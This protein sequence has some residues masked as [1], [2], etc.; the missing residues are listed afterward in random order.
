[1][2][3]SLM[4]TT[5]GM[6]LV[7]A[8]SILGSVLAGRAG[9][10]DYTVRPAPPTLVRDGATTLLVDFSKEKT[11]ADFAAGNPDLSLDPAGFRKNGAYAG[12]LKIHTADNLNP[13]AWTLELVLRLP[14]A[15]AAKD[16]VLGG[17]Q[18][19]KG[20]TYRTRFEIRKGTGPRFVLSS[21]SPDHG[22]LLQ[23]S[24]GGNG[25]TLHRD[26]PAEWVYL[27][28]GLDLENRRA[29]TIL[30]DMEGRVLKGNMDFAGRMGLATHMVKSLPK[31]KREAELARRWKAIAADVAK[32][33]PESFAFGSSAIEVR[34][35]RISHRYRAEVLEVAAA[36]PEAGSN[37]WPAST[38]DPRRT[39][40]QT[41][42]RLIGYPGYRNHRAV[43][44]MERFVPMTK[45]D[46]P[47]TIRLKDMKIG[48][49]SLFIHGTVDPKG[50]E[51]LNRVW[52]P[53]AMEFE[54]R[55]AKGRK[56]A[57][58]RRL[59]KQG[60]RP[61]RMQ[62]F[63][64]HVDTPGDVTATFKLSD[65]AME[66]AR[67]QWIELVD[68]LEG[69]PDEPVKTRQNVAEG[70]KGRLRSLSAERKR[71][72]D[73]IWAALPPLNAHLQVHGQAKPFRSPPPG[74][75]LPPW[76]LKA[77]ADVRSYY[78]IRN[79]LTPL[80]M[81][82]LKTKH[83]FPHDAV[84][85]GMPWPGEFPDDGT[86]LF[87]EKTKHPALPHDIYLTPRADLLGERVRHFVGLLGAWDHG[88]ASL[89]KKYFEKGD[90]N[91]GHDAALA[92]VRVA[93]DWP[94][95]EMNLHEIRLCTHAPD[96]EYN[97]DWSASRNG[98][99]FYEGWSGAM[100]VDFLESYD[101]LFPYI[102]GNPVF[103]DA[104]RRFVPW[105]R[106]PADVVRLLDRYLVFA[107]VR[108]FNRG[109]IR[110]APLEDFAAQVLGPHRLTA[111]M[112]DLTRQHAEIYP[113]KGTYQEL[114]G[115]ALSRSG[116]YYIASFLVYSFGSAQQLITKAH[117]IHV[118]KQNGVTPKMDLSDVR[119]YPKVKRAG[120]FMIDMFVAG[121]FPFM[122]GDAGG[123]PHTGLESPK[124]FRMA[125]DTFGKAF[126]LWGGPRHAWVLANTFGEK[127]ERIV[128]AAKGG[129]DPVLHN[130]SRVVPDYGAIL[131]MD[132]EEPDIVK[133]TAATLRLGIGQGHAHADYLD[134]NFFA[135]GLPVSVDL[136]CRDEG[137]H[138]S[139]PSA[140][141]SFLHNH[142]IAHE[143]DD[144]KRAAGQAGEPWLRA[145]APPLMR[146]SYVNA[147]GDVRLD[148]DV[149]LMQ[150]GDTEQH[151]AF[152]LQRLRGGKLHTW[153]FHG[154]ESK[155][156]KLNVPMQPETV[157]WTDRTLP[158]SHKAG[159]AVNVLQA[160]WTMTREPGEHKHQFKGGGTVK[161]VACEPRVLGKRYDP[162]LP[163]VRV[164]ATLLGR[165]G[166]RVLQGNPYSGPYAYCF[167]FLW[168]QSESRGRESVYPAVYEW[169][170]GDTPVVRS[171]KLLEGE[172]ATVEVQTT[173][174]QRDAYVA[175]GEGFIA[176]SHDAKGL[177]YA[178][179]SGA[180]EVKRGDFSLRAG[181]A[182]HAAG[183]VSIDYARR[184]LATDKPLPADPHAVV[185]NDGRRCYLRLNGAGTRFT[186][187]DDLLIHEGRITDVKVTGP[188]A[189]TV[190]TNQRLI[191]AGSGN[192]K[193]SAFTTT[194]EARTWHFR[195]GKV[196]RKPDGATL[197]KDVFTDA[198]GDGLVNLKTY[199]IGIGDTIQV[200]SDVT[201]RRTGAGYEVRTNVAVEGKI[202][203]TPFNLK[204]APAWQAIKK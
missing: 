10:Y 150:V 124:R 165:A 90:P 2:R 3:S 155:D 83:I 149:F 22:F 122:I 35:L 111:H 32:G 140:G 135:M 57:W 27:A 77:Y 68:P 66:S 191:F 78:R 43:T 56:I 113:Y 166:D 131:E 152:D 15:S 181:S 42:T 64:F 103:A 129:R 132:P 84:V 44:V 161:T 88:G 52:K 36:L 58:G 139:R 115:S 13:S 138:W 45:G 120:D 30:R 112:Y 37:M 40:S 65:R 178:K 1:M 98:K 97:K 102:H 154:C 47:L 130:V 21:W 11:H 159:A 19:A 48:L 172:A 41:A 136:A 16:I 158:G 204:P 24:A 128:A 79:A 157:R 167:P 69:L 63:H 193:P 104:V 105:V 200:P 34:A 127:D 80:D 107:S 203:G 53:C 25:H 180:N 195:N 50:R 60:F 54:A 164:R 6:C 185:G 177:R 82:D 197:S 17:W 38:L 171:V 196:V 29:N 194:N 118:A 199:E 202:S 175:G 108:D 71:R 31:E 189:A 144:P 70:K 95:L 160:T 106:T 87:F 186:W 145:F 173:A 192:R 156:V 169:Y 147:K 85:S 23:P 5:G 116:S 8:V 96:F 74:I 67:I 188:D 162:N 183:I 174:G 110:A 39:T 59:L 100:A 14:P 81:V 4:R 141:W 49:Y 142:A 51:Q 18:G 92:L 143:T 146:A 121:G 91:V 168:V 201:I 93:Y 62:G 148:R 182:G 72:D 26:A 187:E 94:A 7:A 190:K 28:F 114:Y 123:G 117:A 184:T 170:R 126:D 9:A 55:D 119:Q 89:A 61:R 20:T 134:L 76:Q 176:L 101:Q 109:R 99:Y 133:K 153:C 75:A 33:L 73:A 163:P 125:R 151:Y 86:G 12:M 46:A 137:G 198:N 179:V